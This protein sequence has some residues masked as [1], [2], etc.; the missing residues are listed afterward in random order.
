MAAKKTAKMKISAIPLP[1]ASDWRTTDQDE[2]LRRI[3]RAP[4]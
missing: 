4:R 1:P 2:I 3:Q